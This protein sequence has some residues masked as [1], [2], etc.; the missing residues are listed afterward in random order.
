MIRLEL[1]ENYRQSNVEK[2]VSRSSRSRSWHYVYIVQHGTLLWFYET[3]DHKIR[4]KT[5]HNEQPVDLMDA[6]VTV[7]LEYKQKKHVFRV[8]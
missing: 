5:L 7:A 3:R 6:Y 4:G 2:I 1:S 8:Q